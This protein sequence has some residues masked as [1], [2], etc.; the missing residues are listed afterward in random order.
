MM[1]TVSG[2]V[3]GQLRQVSL[4]YEYLEPSEPVLCAIDW[5]KCGGMQRTYCGFPCPAK[6]Y[7]LFKLSEL[8]NEECKK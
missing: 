5:K 4:Y 2:T 3:G 1:T 7:R 6:V 8:L